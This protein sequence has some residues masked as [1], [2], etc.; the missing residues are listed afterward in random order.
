MCFT[1]V[2][3]F[4]IEIYVLNYYF[5]YKSL[6]IS[7][8]VYRKTVFIRRLRFHVNELGVGLEGLTTLRWISVEVVERGGDR[9]RLSLGR[10][11]GRVSDHSVDRV[12]L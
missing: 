5:L 2:C 4:H 7:K 11:V 10:V 12:R 9:D 8:L 6:D 3:I 1:S